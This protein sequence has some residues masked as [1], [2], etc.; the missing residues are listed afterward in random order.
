MH[1]YIHVSHS[2]RSWTNTYAYMQTCTHTYIHVSHG[3]RSCTNT[4]TYMQTCTHTYIHVSHGHRSCTNTYTYMHTCTHTY[5]H[6]SHGH[7][8][9]TIHMHTYIFTHTKTLAL[10]KK[11]EETIYSIIAN[12]P[13]VGSIVIDHV[14][15]VGFPIQPLTEFEFSD[16][17]LATWKWYKIVEGQ[18]SEEDMLLL[19]AGSAY[20]PTVVSCVCIYVLLCSCMYCLFTLLVHLSISCFASFLYLHNTYECMHVWMY[21]YMYDTWIHICMTHECMHICMTHKNIRVSPQ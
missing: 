5:I 16:P 3:H 2:H 1:T 7:V 20:I 14:A 15:M 12:S 8:S 17:A 6:V 11:Q 10:H 21:T 4:H 19:H 13:A 9:C 18:D